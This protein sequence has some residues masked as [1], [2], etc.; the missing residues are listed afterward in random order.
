MYKF[1]Q[2]LYH[3]NSKNAGFFAAHTSNRM[4][5]SLC[6][7]YYPAALPSHELRAA[8]SSKKSFPDN[9]SRLFDTADA[10]MRNL[11]RLIHC[12]ALVFPSDRFHELP[13]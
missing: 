3:I 5:Q 9:N 6:C 1:I 13:L 2:T 4:H 8:Q 11:S 12:P 10:E 7:C